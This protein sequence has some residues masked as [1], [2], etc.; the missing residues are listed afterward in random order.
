MAVEDST[1]CGSTSR[2]PARRCL[3]TRPESHRRRSLR[4][5]GRNAVVDRQYQL[6]RSSSSHTSG[7]C[8]PRARND[9]PPRRSRRRRYAR[10]LFRQ[11]AAASTARPARG[12]AVGAVETWEALV[13]QTS[14]CFGL[15]PLGI[16]DG[17]RCVQRRFEIRLGALVRAAHEMKPE[18]ELALDEGIRQTRGEPQLVLGDFLAA[19][20]TLRPA[21]RS[22]LNGVNDV[23]HVCLASRSRLRLGRQ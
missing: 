6:S 1:T 16:V 9:P 23:S 2:R 7:G 8:I 17:F 12:G 19:A 3:A 22:G 10:N 18:R 13:L 21:A 15:E 5:Q 4:A 11:L 20:A 14:L